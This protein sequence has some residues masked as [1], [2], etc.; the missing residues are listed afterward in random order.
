MKQLNSS[1]HNMETITETAVSS[2]AS[3]FIHARGEV[4]DTLSANAG[5]NKDTVTQVQMKGT[6]SETRAASKPSVGE[7]AIKTDMNGV[8]EAP[9]APNVSEFLPL[10]NAESH[11]KPALHVDNTNDPVLTNK[12]P[13]ID[14]PSTADAVN[15]DGD[16][17][18]TP[19]PIFRTNNQ[20]EGTAT[21]PIENGSRNDFCSP[22]TKLKRRLEESKDLIVCPGVYDGFSARIALSVGFDAMYMA[23][24]RF[25]AS[26]PKPLA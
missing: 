15:G 11:R 5:T 7:A 1:Y 19:T 9:T 3:G 24:P 2:A 21:A 12:K 13:V 8:R 17:I 23:S 14:N 20:Q 26:L 25:L 6:G 18:F 16:G 10:Q 4:N 22:A